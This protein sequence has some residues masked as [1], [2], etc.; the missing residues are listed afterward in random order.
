MIFHHTIGPA[1]DAIFRHC[2]IRAIG[3][4]R[5]TCSTFVVGSSALAGYGLVRT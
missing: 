4:F 1:Y 3:V 5:S 2:H